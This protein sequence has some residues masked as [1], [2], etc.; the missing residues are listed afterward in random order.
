M[1]NLIEFNCI[2]WFLKGLNYL[3]D[4]KALFIPLEELD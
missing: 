2:K 1:L 4:Y 3:G